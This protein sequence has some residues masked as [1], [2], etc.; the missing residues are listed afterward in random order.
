MSVPRVYKFTFFASAFGFSLFISAWWLC[1]YL[2]WH[3]NSNL[4]IPGFFKLIAA[5]PWSTFTFKLS[6]PL[7][8][9]FGNIGR[10][11]ISTII[12][13]IGLGMNTTIFVFIVRQSMR[14][15]NLVARNK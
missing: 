13:A 2:G 3:W 4:N 7:I 10:H 8:S 6:Q 1:R 9:A 14:L 12:I 11:L 5:E 15:F